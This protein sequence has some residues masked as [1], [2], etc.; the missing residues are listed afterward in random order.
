MATV[1]NLELVI[2]KPNYTP[3]YFSGYF[4]IDQKAYEALCDLWTNHPSTDVQTQS[5][6]KDFAQISSL[7]LA[8]GDN[9]QFYSD[10]FKKPEFSEGSNYKAMLEGL[11]KA[12]LEKLKEIKELSLGV[13]LLRDE[14]T[15]KLKTSP[16]KKIK[17][18]KFS[19]RR[20]RKRKDIELK[21][22]V[23]F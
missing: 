16:G 5:F 9:P 18:R 7:R 12:N 17:L 19:N 2:P 20:R 3:S 11:Q 23:S 13:M 14:V 1:K 6:L 21:F 4:P 8:N 15:K 10:M 22:R